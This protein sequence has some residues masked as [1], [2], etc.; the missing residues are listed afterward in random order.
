MSWLSSGL[1]K[2]GGVAEKVAPYVGLIPG[3]GTIAGGAI[4]GL[5][6]LAHGDGLKGALKYGAAGAISGYGNA[7]KLGGMGAKAIFQGGLKKVG[8]NLG[9]LA[10]GG[11]LGGNG[12][13]NPDVSGALNTANGIADKYGSQGGGGFLDGLKKVGGGIVGMGSGVGMGGSHG[14]FLDSILGGIKGIGVDGALA[15]AAGLAGA[16]ASRN[17]SNYRNKALGLVQGQWDDKAPLRKVGL[18]G[19]LNEQRPDLSSVYA[20]PQNPFARKVG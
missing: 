15:G 2:V 8:S 7:A 3:V 4:G 19:M 13:P 6:A 10:M 12:I 16:N 11:K 1:K 5:G 14:G 18:A 9:T 17:A 20:D